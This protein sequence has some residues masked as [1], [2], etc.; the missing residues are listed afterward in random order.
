MEHGHFKLVSTEPLSLWS[1]LQKS[2]L[3][4]PK[5]KYKEQVIPKPFIYNSVLAA[6]YSREMVAQS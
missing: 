6:S 2:T 4:I 5:E 3:R 1:L